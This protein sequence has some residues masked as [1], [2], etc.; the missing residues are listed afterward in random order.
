MESQILDVNNDKYQLLNQV[1]SSGKSKVF[2]GRE[3]SLKDLDS[4]DNDKIDAYV[5]IYE[6]NYAN[7]IGETMIN[8]IIYIY[9]RVINKVL[10]IDSV[11]TLQDD[12]TGDYIITSELRNVVGSLAST[13][14]KLMTLVNLSFITFKHVKIPSKELV[15]ELVEEHC[16]ELCKVDTV[17]S[18]VD[19]SEIDSH[20]CTLE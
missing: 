3:I 8:N 7:K 14:G 16:E 12:L 11:K 6:L 13:C 15:K 2:L 10:P 17:V 9:S 19:Q 20:Q 5:K 18:I 4:M 1:I